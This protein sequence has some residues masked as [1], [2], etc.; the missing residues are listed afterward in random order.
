MVSDWT[1][2]TEDRRYLLTLPPDID[3]FTFGLLRGITGEMNINITVQNISDCVYDR[4]VFSVHEYLR[5]I[6]NGTEGLFC[7]R[8]FENQTW[9]KWFYFIYHLALGFNFKCYENTDM[10]NPIL[11]ERSTVIYLL[12]AI[13]LI[14]FSHHPVLLCY[15][16]RWQDS[17]KQLDFLT[18]ADFPYTPRRVL[19]HFL[20][21]N[22]KK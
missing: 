16:S 2:V 20:F 12:I 4:I 14:L 8:Y 6:Q 19:L 11:L 5:N 10:S 7:H 22:K 13:S 9:K 3:V 17:D 15:F 21:K 18:K 1:W